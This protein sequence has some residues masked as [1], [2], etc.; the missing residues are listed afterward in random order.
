MENDGAMF[1]VIDAYWN[2][3]IEQ[4]ETKEDLVKIAR[5]LIEKNKSMWRWFNGIV[6]GKNESGS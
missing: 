4:A 2:K 3:R 5:E 6:G 1:K